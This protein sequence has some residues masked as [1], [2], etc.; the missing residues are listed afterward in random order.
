MNIGLVVHPYGEAKPSGLGRA[1][2]QMVKALV[3]SDREN[4]YTLYFKE[5]PIKLPDI[6]GTWKTNV[7]NVKRLLLHAGGLKK[8][9]EDLFIFFTPVIP[10]TFFPKKSIVVVHDLG[11]VR[12]P[13]KGLKAHSIACILY[14]SY[15]IS[16]RKADKV[17]AVSNATKEDVCRYFNLKSDKV[18]VVHNG[19]TQPTAQAK[20][21]P[22]PEHFFLFAGALKERKNVARIIDAFIS[23]SK[24][25]PDV[26]LLL[27]GKAEGVYVEKLKETVRKAGLADRV[28]FLGYVSDEELAYLYSKTRAFI[29]PSLLEGFGLTI[30]EA[31]S[32]GAPVITSNTGA[33][34]EVAGDSALLVDPYS[35][36]AIKGTMVE[37]VRNTPL[38]NRLIE[39]GKIRAE[40][41]SWKETGEG[42]MQ[43][44]CGVR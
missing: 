22:C 25:Q 42:F 14:L 3:E 39:K 29:F 7:L 28:Q 20:A 32:Q 26:H 9:T 17:I 41:F 18:V 35:T 27:V 37:I 36:E 23:F 6:K 1:I 12:L 5:T 40:S 43:V 15:F 19:F 44:I 2:S 16:L 31:M 11:F 38:R 34:A 30:L 8:N 21:F 24:T 4:T 13:K 33:L 10:L